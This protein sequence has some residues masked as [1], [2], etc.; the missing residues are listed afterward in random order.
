MRFV[1]GDL[2]RSLARVIARGPP[3]RVHRPLKT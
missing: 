2:L 1:S 3:A